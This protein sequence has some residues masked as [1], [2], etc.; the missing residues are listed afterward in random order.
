MEAVKHIDEVD[1]GAKDPNHFVYNASVTK[2]LLPLL[3]TI[4]PA[5]KAAIPQAHLT[6]IGGYYRF[7]EGAEPDEQEKT[8]HKL[9]EQ[10]APGVTFTGSD[11]SI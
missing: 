7:R 9:M 11:S 4:W 2:G 8:L 1:V 10:G 6:V 5:V 3:G